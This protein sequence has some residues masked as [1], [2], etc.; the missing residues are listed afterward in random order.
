MCPA[1]KGNQ[2]YKM[3]AKWGEH[4]TKYT[5]ATFWAKVIEFL[6]WCDKYPLKSEEVFGTG[7]R[8]TVKNMRMPTI[9]GFCTYAKIDRQTFANY[10]KDE[11]WFGIVTRARDLFYAIK[12]EGAAAGLLNANIIARELGLSDKTEVTGTFDIKQITGMKVE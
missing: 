3:V 11:A 5:P 6:Q 7:K 9:Q 12:I 4:P 8:M 10:E 2:Y 1:P